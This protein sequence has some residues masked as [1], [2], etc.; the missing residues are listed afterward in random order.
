MRPP[1][2][3]AYLSPMRKPEIPLDGVNRVTLEVEEGYAS[4]QRLDQLIVSRL[5]KISRNR[6]QKLISNGS[7]L[8]NGH[9]CKASTVVQ[10]GASIEIVFPHPP[11]PPASPEDIPLEVVYEDDALLI[12]NK[13]AGMV[14]H[15]A[16]GHS[17]GTLV[18]ALL[19]RYSS[20]PNPGG[21]TVRPGIVHRL[22]KE[23]SGLLVIAKNEQVMTALARRFHDHDIEREYVALVWGCP[24][25]KGT[26][27]APIARHPGNRK[28]FAVV[29]GGRRAVTHWKLREQ[30]AFV[31]LV[32]LRLET[33][34]THQIRVHMAHRGWPV[35]GDSTYGGRLHGLARMTSFRR[36]SAREA[37][38]RMPRQALHARLLGFE[39]P[40]TGEHLRLSAEMPADMQEVCNYLRESGG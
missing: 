40:V 37:L 1:L 28:K 24:P 12:V 38:E 35:F 31:S 2:V 26:I 8:M 36:S 10:S 3:N 32:A 39:H 19:G 25:E 29:E 15:P 17:G 11:R 34:R 22:D 5:P 6:V 30:F 18:N 14:V 9:P 4:G 21:P 20:L 7:V 33:G 23:T 27:D 16:A 13:P